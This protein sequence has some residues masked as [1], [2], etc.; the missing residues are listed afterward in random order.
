MRLFTACL[1]AAL[2]ALAGLA[3]P[4]GAAEVEEGK[5][6]PAIDLPA[7]QI[8]KALP[9][10]KDAKTL[11]LKDLR[12]K[13]V[14][15]FFYPKASTPGCTTQA[16]G[17]R[18]LNDEF[19]KL[20]TVIVGISTDPVSAQE[21]FTRDHKLPFPLFADADKKIAK[22]YGVLL[23][24]GV[25]SRWTFVIDKEGNVRKIFKNATPAKNPKETL[26]FV[27]VN[28]AKGK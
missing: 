12:G 5:P 18:D 16:C 24:R 13:N 8:E 4:A 22:E 1:L 2:L 19:A 7:T 26:E 15:L 21:K 17:F 25:A 11:S 9:D 28:L 6:A 14:V 20:N 23:P 10:K 3:L 27:K